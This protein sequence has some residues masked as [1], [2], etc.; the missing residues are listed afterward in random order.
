[1]H[2]NS[3]DTISRHKRRKGLVSTNLCFSTTLRVNR[4]D[5]LCLVFRYL[6][7]KRF[8]SPKTGIR[9]YKLCWFIRQV[10]G[11][12]WFYYFLLLSKWWLRRSNWRA[13]HSH[14]AQWTLKDGSYKNRKTAAERQYLHA[15]VVFLSI[16]A[17]MA[18]DHCVG[19]KIIR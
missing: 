7:F 14:G 10:I 11:F 17:L 9:T 19:I 12:M 13:G 2:C 5:N 1:M 3:G 16:L 8:V 4:F 18:F 6:A 15:E